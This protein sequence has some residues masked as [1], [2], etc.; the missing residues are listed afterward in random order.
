MEL[1]EVLV[2]FKSHLLKLL[3][4]CFKTNLFKAQNCLAL[5]TSQIRT[6]PLVSDKIFANPCLKNI[7]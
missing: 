2:F 1:K 7:R 4:A 5:K 3:R 6:H